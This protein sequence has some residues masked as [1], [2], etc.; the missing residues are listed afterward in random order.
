MSRP[1]NN[2]TQRTVK[3]LLVPLPPLEEQARILAL[4]G[5]ETDRLASLACRV[6]SAVTHL[7]EYRAALISAAVTGRIDVRR[8]VVP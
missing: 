4:L 7:L 1:A 3:Q 6:R 8:E 5:S 2:I